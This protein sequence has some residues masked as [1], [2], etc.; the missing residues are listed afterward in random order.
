M[1]RGRSIYGW[2]LFV[3]FW[4]VGYAE[5][6]RAQVNAADEFEDY[7]SAIETDF[8]NFEDSINRDF[9]DYLEQAWQ[10]F[11][12]YEG[13]EPPV[14]AG[15]I[16]CTGTDDF[17]FVQPDG[18]FF[19]SLLHFPYPA[20]GNLS[21][22]GLSEKEVA[23]GWRELGAEDF[24]SFFGTYKEYSRQ[25]SLNDWGNYQLLKYACRMHYPSFTHQEQTLFLFFTLSNA[26]YRVKIGRAGKDALVLLLPFAEEV[27]KLPFIRAEEKKYYVMDIS[28]RQLKKLYSIVSDY[29][30]AEKLVSL[31]IPA[32]LTF[33]EKEVGREYTGKYPFSLSLNRNLL[34]FYATFPLCDLSVYFCAE[35][36]G[37][38]ARWMDKIV[39]VHLD[40]KA[41]LEQIAWL[42]DFVQQTFTHKPDVE[43]HKSEVYYFPEETAFN[44]YADCEDLSVFLS[45]LVGRYVASEVLVLYYPSHVAIAVERCE[46]YRGEVLKYRN[47]EYMICDP[48]YR[49]AAPGKVIPA[50]ASLKPVIV[51]YSK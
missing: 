36:S 31:K 25:F 9:A 6:L 50:C 33:P 17:P 43:V 18:S 8:Y 45:W 38:F 34:D 16:S 32:A 49:G 48:S 19:G 42:L 46:G 2:L 26:G 14:Y 1:K 47:R 41:R 5:P 29:P 3:C 22:S 44:P 15:G 39:K 13:I 30:K 20:G 51:S 7:L 11:T 12:V 4:N 21:L 27:Y 23:D 10:E 24:T 35:P 40:G 28:S 37:A